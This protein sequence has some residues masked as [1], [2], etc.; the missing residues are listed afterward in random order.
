M[1][2][3]AKFTLTGMVIL[4]L[5]LISIIA[6]TNLCDE[7]FFGTALTWCQIIIVL[8]LALLL[9]AGQLVRRRGIKFSE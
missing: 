9:G 6:F 5:L 2:K 1:E 3:V 8:I 7:P 4:F